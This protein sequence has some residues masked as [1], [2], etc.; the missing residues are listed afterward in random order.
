M[1][2]LESVQSTICAFVKLAPCLKDFPFVGLDT[3][4]EHIF[5]DDGTMREA[6]EDSLKAIGWAI[7]VSPPVGA[8]A[9]S[10]VAA[11]STS[12]SGAG[13][14]NVLTNIAVRTNPKKNSGATAI[15]PLVAVK[16]IIQAALNWQPTG[17]EKGFTLN[18]ELPFSPDF[19]DEGCYTYDIKLL[20]T[21]SLL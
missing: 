21:V 15:V 14:Y 10:Q 19:A 12:A 4:G 1:L 2:K 5:A 8:S 18:D 16:Q 17:Q 13:Y 6:I 20:K 9:K 7:V 3:I 11:T